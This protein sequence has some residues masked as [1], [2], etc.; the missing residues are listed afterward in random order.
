[1]RPVMG[2]R[3]AVAGSLTRR[4]PAIV[5]EDAAVS[6]SRRV[7]RSL[8]GSKV[9]AMTIRIDAFG[10]G[11]RSGVGFGKGSHVARGRGN[12]WRRPR[13]SPTLG[14]HSTTV[15]PVS[16]S[17]RPSM[18]CGRRHP[19]RASRCSRNDTG[20]PTALASSRF[21]LDGVS[22]MVAQTSLIA[23]P[24]RTLVAGRPT[25]VAPQ[26]RM[27]TRTTRPHPTPHQ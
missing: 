12:S 8:V 14:R 27:W 16:A 18:S 9:S 23:T 2:I 17:R 25:R 1:M 15:R 10:G 22:T 20:S 4:G 6:C 24:L 3:Y 13:C 11:G 7:Q 5:P 26:S 21:I 19:A